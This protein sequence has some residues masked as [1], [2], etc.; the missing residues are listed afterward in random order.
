MHGPWWGGVG[1]GGGESALSIWNVHWTGICGVALQ[2]GRTAAL[3]QHDCGAGASARPRSKGLGAENI[4]SED[5]E[6]TKLICRKLGAVWFVVL[7]L[8]CRSCSQQR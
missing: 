6:H 2:V 4:P 1:G 3:K 8:S 7:W 5:E